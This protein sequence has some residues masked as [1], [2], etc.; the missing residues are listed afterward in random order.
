MA[1]TLKSKSESI[2]VK[3]KKLL[4]F[5]Q[6]QA[7]LGKRGPELFIV[8]FGPH[9]KARSL[10]TTTQE[11]SAFHRSE[12]IQDVY[13]LIESVAATASR[14][15]G[16]SATNG[17][18]SVTVPLPKSV[19]AALMQEA[20]AEGVTLDQLCLSKLVAQLRELV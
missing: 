19:H 12:E 16:S 3:A 20:A 5:A 18:P 9:G 14:Y 13:K 1:V 8:V 7:R 6:E 17:Q 15:K 4:E 11:W 10:F 2:K